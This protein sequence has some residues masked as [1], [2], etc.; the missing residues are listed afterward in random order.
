MKHAALGLFLT[1]CFGIFVVIVQC[2]LCPLVAKISL[3]P[4]GIHG[5]HV[6]GHER[7][8]ALHFTISL[9]KKDFLCA[10]LYFY[11]LVSL[12]IFYSNVLINWKTQLTQTPGPFRSHTALNAVV[13]TEGWSRSPWVW[14]WALEAERPGLQAQSSPPLYTYSFFPWEMGITLPVWGLNGQVCINGLAPH[15]C[16]INVNSH[17]S[18]A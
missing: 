16:P 17:V 14:T 9:S 18:L 11:S 8:F 6:Q 2:T 4:R 13:I 10:F 1:T 5:N 3:D 12:S 15:D 7:G